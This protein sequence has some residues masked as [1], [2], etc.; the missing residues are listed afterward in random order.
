[1]RKQI[2]M[3]YEYLLCLYEVRSIAI[4]IY[5]STI[6]PRSRHE[7]TPSTNRTIIERKVVIFTKDFLHKTLNHWYPPAHRQVIV[8]KHHQ[9]IL[10]PEIL[11]LRS[12]LID[13]LLISQC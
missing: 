2:V 5:P 8:S 9:H 1:M 10:I 3:A 11:L 7:L 6:E 12:L 4:L 13:K